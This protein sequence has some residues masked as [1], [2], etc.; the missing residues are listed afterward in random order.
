VQKVKKLN[1]FLTTIARFSTGGKHLTQIP[2]HAD[3]SQVAKNVTE[4]IVCDR[5]HEKKEVRSVTIS[6]KIH[7]LK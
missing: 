5:K 3:F 7:I 6:A 2:T 4:I 1:N